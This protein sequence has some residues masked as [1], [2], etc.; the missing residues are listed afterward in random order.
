MRT[1]ELVVSRN[2][3]TGVFMKKRSLGHR[4]KEREKNT[5]A[6]GGMGVVQGKPRKA[7]H[8]LQLPE[9]Y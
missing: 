7:K 6:E 1:Y 4:D 8:C 5:M 3:M 9:S 2:P